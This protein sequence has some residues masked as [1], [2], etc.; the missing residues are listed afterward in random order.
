MGTLLVGG[1]WDLL[2]G[3]QYPGHTQFVHAL[4]HYIRNNPSVSTYATTFQHATIYTGE[5]CRPEVD[6]KGAD[7]LSEILHPGE[8]STHTV[9]IGGPEVNPH[10]AQL[11]PYLPIPFKKDEYWYLHTDHKVYNQTHGI[12]AAI[13]VNNHTFLIVAG[14]GGT[15][16][17]GAVALLQHIQDYSLN[18]HYN[19]YGEAVLFCVSGD[20][21]QNG[22]QEPTEQWKISIL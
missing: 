21:N 1:S 4:L 15:G 14:L 19:A 17:T 18:L 3:L 22:V 9:I 7:I 2:S 12:I 8:S 13:T 11:I 16:T 6:Q 10:C 5:H 20:T